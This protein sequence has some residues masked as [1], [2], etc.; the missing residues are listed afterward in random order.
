M[1]ED[2]VSLNSEFYTFKKGNLWRHHFDGVDRNNFYGEQ[3]DSSVELLFNEL[4]GS[5][6]S[7]QTLNY[8][9]SQSKITPPIDPST[10]DVV[11]GEYWDNEIKE[12][13]LTAGNI[14]TNEFSYQ[15]IDESESITVISGDYS[16]WNC[17]EVLNINCDGGNTIY[18][19]NYGPFV[20]GT[21][22]I[23]VPNQWIF[24]MVAWFI[25]NAPTAQFSE[26][27]FK[28][29]GP[30]GCQ[31]LGLTHVNGIS[32]ASTTGNEVLTNLYNSG[33]LTA[34]IGASSSV[35]TSGMGSYYAAWGQSN[36]WR[37]SMYRS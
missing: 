31:A 34:E 14:D 29:C 4:P 5:V 24:L 17:E 20:A 8:E 21:I 30:S 28:I 27:S 19:D 33:F 22:L 35:I 1:Q 32:G 23:S 11:D 36:F 6:K 25:D 16:S 15:G 37:V 3:Y 7:F 2:G 26:Y 12:D 9:G 13:D 10:G 18:I